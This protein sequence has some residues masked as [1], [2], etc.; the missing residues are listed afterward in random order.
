MSICESA[1]QTLWGNITPKLINCLICKLMRQVRQP[2]I[3]ILTNS[4]NVL[5]EHLV[6]LSE[7]GVIKNK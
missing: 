1:T 6:K 4:N 3:Y 7:Q 2:L 5:A